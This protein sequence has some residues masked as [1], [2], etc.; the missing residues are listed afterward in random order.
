MNKDHDRPIFDA[1]APER[2]QVFKHFVANFHYNRVIH[3]L[4]DPLKEQNIDN[5]WRAAKRPKI[6]EVL[7]RAFPQSEWGV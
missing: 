5:Y 4:V 6:L 1:T 7:R 2:R 3:D